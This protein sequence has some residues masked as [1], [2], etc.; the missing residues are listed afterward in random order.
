M[1]KVENL[2]AQEVMPLC[3]VATARTIE[4]MITVAVNDIIAVGTIELQLKDRN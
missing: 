2:V 3:G 1:A 4:V